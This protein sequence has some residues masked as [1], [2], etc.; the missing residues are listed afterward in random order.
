MPVPVD[1][2]APARRIASLLASGTEIL[3]ALGLE[4]RLVAISH[5]CDYP[6]RVLDRPRLSRPRFEPAGLSSGELDAAVRAAMAQHGSVYAVDDEELATLAPD[7][8]LAQAVCE[9]CAVPT[10][11]VR[12]IVERR[13]IDA[14][15]LSLDAH[16]VE[17]IVR[18]ILDVG[19]AA[20]VMERAQAV[21]AE[22]R[23]RIAAVRTGVAGAEPVRVLA[24]EWLD[25]P[26]VPGHWVP[27]MIQLAGGVNLAGAVGRPSR[28]VEWSDIAGLDPDVL[29]LMPCGYGL[30]ATIADANR[31][32][33][34][35]AP[36]AP[37][38]IADGCAFVVDGSAYFNRSGPRVVDGIEILAG[39]LHPGRCP[40]PPRAV[41]AAWRPPSS[42][43]GS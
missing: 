21:V 30:D 18:S 25:P 27:E 2:A 24:L 34:A 39:L 37:R 19:A 36:L 32:A 5:E 29:L 28:Q 31:S 23:A 1:A 6:P 35:I 13:G 20:G 16:T 17:D 40:P 10:L 11:G 15:I 26:F 9:V 4:D 14:R 8:I 43:H 7:L 22:L 12:D 38:A 41:A 42:N 33:R 3:V